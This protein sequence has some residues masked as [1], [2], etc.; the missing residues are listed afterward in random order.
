[1]RVLHR[2]AIAIGLGV[3]LALGV[4]GYAAAGL[5]VLQ[6]GLSESG[7]CRAEH[8]AFTPANFKTDVWV[9]DD[10]SAKGFDVQQY[11]MPDFSEVTFPSRGEPAITIHAWWVPGPRP[12][13]PAVVAVH[14]A[15]SCRR[16][17]AILVPAGMLHRQGFGVL[18]IDMRDNG[19]STREDGR[20]GAG[21]DEYRDVLGAWDW[22]VGQGVPAARIGA[23]GQSGGAAAVVVAMGEEPRLAAGWEESGPSD[24]TTAVIEELR[25]DHYPEWLAPAVT[26]WAQVF[27]DD[28]VGRSPLVEARKVG[29]RPFQVVHGTA[30][31]RIAVHHATDLE[32]VLQAANPS[33]SA[34]LIQD[35]QHVQG[36]FLVPAEY[37]GRLGTFF[38][39]ALGS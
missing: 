35:G 4:A 8:A 12:D 7:G 33:N 28:I 23:F 36:P 20:Y 5:A 38:H 6:I 13:G 26:A 19:D 22:L 9:S 27:G 32:A 37:E 16:D 34:W 17:P 10:F 29:T 1:M 25:R 30:D 31:K 11:L 3:T 24:M 21:S 18:L 14:G 39:A 15:G 2:R